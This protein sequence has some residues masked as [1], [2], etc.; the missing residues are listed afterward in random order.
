MPEI[1][2]GLLEPGAAQ[3]R[4]LVGELTALVN[5]VYAV[6]E[7]GIWQPDADRTSAT[8]MTGLI[9]SGEIAVARVDGEVAGAVRMQAVADD[10]GEFGML[11]AD[12][13]RRG[14]GIGRELVR[15]AERHYSEAG[16]RAMQLELL[17]PREWKH[18]NKV[19]LDGWYR[20]IGYRIVRT[21]TLDESY[22][23]LEPLLATE[24]RFVIYEKRL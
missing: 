8:E 1:E 4:D 6:A 19:F 20:R 7:K 17:V 3:D 21:T 10:T 16:M 24:C 15:F 13:E 11:V 14:M 18:P 2:V 22:P 12:P 5:E 23:E 9:E